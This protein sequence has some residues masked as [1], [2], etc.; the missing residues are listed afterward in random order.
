MTEEERHLPLVWFLLASSSLGPCRGTFSDQ[1]PVEV[2]AETSPAAGGCQLV[3]DD[4]R[5]AVSSGQC[6]DRVVV[7]QCV[8]M[9]LL[10]N[11]LY[12]FV[13]QESPVVVSVSCWF[14]GQCLVS[15]CDVGESCSWSVCH[16]GSLVSV[17]YR[18]VV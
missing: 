3:H 16:V 4:D 12:R 6:V 18:F 9:V 7:M 2:E 17:L 15:V 14:A 1:P 13:V 5:H 8:V 10:V 11:V